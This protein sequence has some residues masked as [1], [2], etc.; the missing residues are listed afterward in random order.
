M[1]KLLCFK[2]LQITDLLLIPHSFLWN[3]EHLKNYKIVLLYD[4]LPLSEIKI[5]LP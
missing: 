3:G 4:Y 2:Y 5:K 1:P